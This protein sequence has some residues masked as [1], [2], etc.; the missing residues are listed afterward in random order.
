MK[1]CVKCGKNDWSWHCEN[2]FMEGTCRGCGAKTN[3]FKAD[4]KHREKKQ[5]LIA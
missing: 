1:D 2:G 3:K 4:G 5:D